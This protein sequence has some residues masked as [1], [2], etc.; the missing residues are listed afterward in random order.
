MNVTLPNGVVVENVPDDIT[1]EE[2]KR[3]V[4]AGGIATEKDFL[5]GPEPDFI[6]QIEETIKGVPAGAINLGELA[7]LG[8]ISPLGE[9]SEL[10]ARQAIQETAATLRSPFEADPGSEEAVGRKF[11]EALGSFVGLGATTLIP[12]VG[13]PAAVALAGGAGAG[14][15]SERARA[16]GASAEERATSAVLGTAVGLSELIPIN[17]LGRLRRG[18]GEDGLKGII[19]RVKRAAVAGGAE[20]AQEAA[21]GVAQNLIE[22]GVYNPEQG[23]F[24]DTGEAFGYGAGVGGFVQGILDLALPKTRGKGVPDS[25]ETSDASVEETLLLGFNPTVV[26]TNPDGSVE[27]LTREEAEAR[28]LNFDDIARANEREAQAIEAEIAAE[29][30][31]LAAIPDYPGQVPE[32]V[33]DQVMEDAQAE[34]EAI[35][36]EQ[37]AEQQARVAEQDEAARKMPVVVDQ[38]DTIEVSPEGVAG[39]RAQ[40][41][42]A[43][44]EARQQQEL[45]ERQREAL[46]GIPEDIR[47]VKEEREARELR[48]QEGDLFPAQRMAAEREGLTSAQARGI[49]ESARPPP[50]VDEKPETPKQVTKKFFDDLGIAKKADVRQKL[51]GQKVNDARLREVLTG[52]A[53]RKSTS[54]KAKTNINQFLATTPE[55]GRYA[56]VPQT[57]QVAFDFRAKPTRRQEAPTQEAPTQEVSTQEAPT[58]GEPDVID[59]RGTQQEPSGVSVQPVG[60][61]TGGA[62]RP[63]TTTDTTVGPEGTPTL[64]SR[65]L[66]STEQRVGPAISG[67]T[68][69]GDALAKFI[70]ARKLRRTGTTPT[71]EV[72]P[73]PAL[74]K[75]KDD[76]KAKALEAEDAAIDAAKKK[77]AERVKKA[78]AAEEK[79][80]KADVAKRR[81]AKKKAEEQRKADVAKLQGESSFQE[82]KAERK[83]R[84]EK[85][86]NELKTRF[87]PK[88]KAEEKNLRNRAR[89]EIA[90][91]DSMSLPNVQYNSDLDEAL[92]ADAV[93]MLKEGDLKGALESIATTIE[94]TTLARH[95]KNLIKYVGDTRIVV[96]PRKPSDAVSRLY[97]ERLDDNPN[98]VGLFV[99]DNRINELNNVILL[100]ENIGLTPANVLHE[101]THAATYATIQNKSHP[102]RN[103]LNAIFETVRDSLSDVYGF[104]NLDEFVAEAYSNPEFQQKL[105]TIRLKGDKVTVWQKVKNIFGNFIRMLQG[106]SKVPVNSVPADTAVNRMIDDIL[107][108]WAG[109]RGAGTLY[110]KVSMGRA[111]EF[112]NDAVT[113]IPAFDKDSEATLTEKLLGS[114]PVSA[115]R[116]ALSLLD[117]N[118]IVR[119]SSERIPRAEDLLN[120]IRKQSGEV[121]TMLDKAETLFKD[122]GAWSSNNQEKASALTKLMGRSTLLRVDPSLDAT[123]ARKRY[124]NEK[125]DAWKD[126][127][128]EWN[129]LGKEGQTYYKRWRTAYR[130]MY[131]DIVN[132]LDNRLKGEGVN[133][134]ARK[135]VVNELY[136]KM[137]SNG[138]ID[139]YFPLIR[140]GKVWLEYNAIDPENGNV[141]YYLEAFET[142]AERKKAIQQIKEHWTNPEPRYKS[143]VEAQIKAAKQNPENKGKSEAEIIKAL[144]KVNSFSDPSKASYQN[145]PPASFVND[146]LQILQINKVEESTQEDIMRLYLDALPERS[147]AQSFRN[148][149][150]R[151][152]FMG[153]VTPTERQVPAGDMFKA[154][155][156]RAYNISHQV[157]RVKYGAEINAFQKMISEERDKLRKATGVRPEE[158][159]DLTSLYLD[160]LEARAQWAANPVVQNWAKVATGVG[161]NATL[162]L[163]LSSAMVNLSQLPMVTLPYLGGQYGFREATK[164]M[165]RASKLFMASGRV[166]NV[167]S[168]GVE[169]GKDVQSKQGALWS[170][171]NYDF[172]D[173]NLN[174][175]I[176]RYET[177]VKVASEQGQ[178]NRSIAYDILD[179]GD[180]TNP[181][182]KINAVTGFFFHHGERMN[183]QI[184]MAA[185]YDLALNKMKSDGRKIDEAARQEAAIEAIN[186]TEMTNGG[187]AAASAP[188]F[189]QDGLGKVVFLFKRYASAMYFMLGSLAHRSIKGSDKDRA[190]ARRQLAGVFGGAGIVAGI[191]GLPLFGVLAM[192]HD[193]FKED[194]EED[195]ET[196]VRQYFGEGMYGG[197]GNYLFG[198]DVASRMGL[199]N[200]VFRDRL[201]EKDQSIL[202]TTA[203]MLGGPVVGTALQVERGFDQIAD[204]NV[205]RGVETAMPAAIRNV[206]KSTR[207]AEEGA[208]TQRG[209][210]IVEDIGPGHIFAQAVGFAPAEYTLQLQKN[211][212]IKKIDRA[213]NEERTKLLKK[214]YVAL[215]NGD[216]LTMSELLDDMVDF[217]GRHP[218]VAITPD[219]IKRSMKQ[220]MR[221]TSTMYHGITVS[222]RRRAEALDFVSDY[223]QTPNVWYDIAE[224]F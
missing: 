32:Q 82:A 30:E 129:G 36:A 54:N 189:A 83:R 53:N 223:D 20:G 94:N 92:S 161:F 121:N 108:P 120:I 67:T 57:G 201:I 154:Y 13:I 42:A 123:T 132:V 169:V 158:E 153:D 148:R 147:F 73:A 5:S 16:A 28:D 155:R 180:I 124:D 22:Q 63:V 93:A 136:Q 55:Q 194:D 70:D 175:E 27:R 84:V 71:Q 198:V 26:H 184:S 4:I 95:A 174:P 167:D 61:T 197:L 62:Q 48:E 98:V 213:V 81:A 186:V 25:D 160:E 76:A 203:E 219:T 217:N 126:M 192:T 50:V 172:S 218:I 8:L 99:F 44:S 66:G 75:V 35:A 3:R 152:G 79:K 191:Q 37:E 177:L 168:Y 89:R 107:A 202:W 104:T 206:I 176:K 162:G 45:E 165:G 68:E 109:S 182:A 31:R 14:E 21:A 58:Q 101:M 116:F 150:D 112:L 114:F 65:G 96:V 40:Q 207:F 11:G 149:K 74:A 196:S 23:A 106:K 216:G 64:E 208:K 88:N 215:R 34:A 78:K 188:R 15:A 12:G 170:L 199:S 7:A 38:P 43:T 97:R 110:N 118:A 102:I 119:M 157:A 113:S 91:E 86:F 85:R 17:V 125:F 69:S 29:E 18:L 222:P 224:N 163:N 164:A 190:M 178:L 135:T 131:D 133:A 41:E 9:E 10:E 77:E 141:E 173:P 159:R 87:A 144:S 56:Q 145:A 200:L 183:R 115:K 111:K 80:K 138:V 122:V 221:T 130:T 212:Q 46:G 210:P 171:D 100:D 72:A 49:P 204:G 39:T 19:Q 166:R 140:Q 181:M 134:K 185:A 195:F 137:I 117:L 6:D 1:Q 24:T 214:Y 128:S 187:I 90:E 105:A 146:V 103:Q 60:E 127:Q 2:L 33:P 151:R 209:D 143:V 59:D 142:K 47:A 139:P 179:L 220:H 156:D 51:Q 211:A 205:A 52:Y 193:L